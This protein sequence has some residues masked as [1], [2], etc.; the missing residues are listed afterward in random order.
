MARAL[1]DLQLTA[2]QGGV[3]F[4]AV[5][6]GDDR[7]A[8]TPDDQQRHLFREIEAIG[9]GDALPLGA[10]YRA[11]GRQKGLAASRLGEEA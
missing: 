6:S 2:R 9:G 7:V 4:F 3:G 5:A 11:Q 1:E 10:D 8:G